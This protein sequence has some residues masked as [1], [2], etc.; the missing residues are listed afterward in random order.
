MISHTES[1]L[2]REFCIVCS[3][4]LIKSTLSSFQ[5]QNSIILSRCRVFT[6]LVFADNTTRGRQQHAGWKQEAPLKELMTN[7]YRGLYAG[8]L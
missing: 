5:L 8:L 1:T 6:R 7:L 2:N 3:N 4:P